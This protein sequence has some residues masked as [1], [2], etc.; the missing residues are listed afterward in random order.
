[1][2]WVFE[3]LQFWLVGGGLLLPCCIAACRW[4]LGGV[5]RAGGVLPC[6]CK[7]GRWLFGAV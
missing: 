4:A 7:V 5:M 3:L 2:C 1:M 6:V